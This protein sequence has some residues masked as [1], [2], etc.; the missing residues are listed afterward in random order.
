MKEGGGDKSDEHQDETSFDVYIQY[1][2]N[3]FGKSKSNSGENE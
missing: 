3:R 1:I 2:E